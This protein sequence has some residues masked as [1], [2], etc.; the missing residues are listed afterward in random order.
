MAHP[1]SEIGEEVDV[2]ANWPQYF[3]NVYIFESYTRNLSSF[4]L[5]VILCLLMNCFG[6]P[7]VIFEKHSEWNRWKTWKWGNLLLYNS[8]KLW[9]CELHL[10]TKCFLKILRLALCSGHGT[11]P[12]SQVYVGG[13]GHN[14]HMLMRETRKGAPNNDLILLHFWED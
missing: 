2:L 10:S 12:I 7:D 4:Y 8:V 13:W 6:L 3:Q 1:R 9:G 14:L 5:Y 11:I